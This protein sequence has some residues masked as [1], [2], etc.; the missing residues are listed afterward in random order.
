MQINITPYLQYYSFKN[1]PVQVLLPSRRASANSLSSLLNMQS[2]SC[3][4]ARLTSSWGLPVPHDR[5]GLTKGLWLVLLG[6]CWNLSCRTFLASKLKCEYR[7][8][9]KS[10]MVPSVK[11]SAGLLVVDGSFKRVL[12]PGDSPGLLVVDWWTWARPQIVGPCWRTSNI[13]KNINSKIHL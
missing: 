2:I 6:C 8:S 11:G 3:I 4:V 5:S 7:W 10:L 1:I 12:P 13:L 9:I